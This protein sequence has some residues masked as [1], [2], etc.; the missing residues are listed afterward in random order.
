M[1]LFTYF[2]G[3]SLVFAACGNDKMSRTEADQA[4]NPFSTAQSHS[5]SLSE[6]DKAK[7][8][9]AIGKTSI[10]VSENELLQKINTA[11]DRLH[12]FCF[13]SLKNRQNAESLAAVAQ[14]W[15]STQI[16]ICYINIGDA[17]LNEVHLAIREASLADDNYRLESADLHFLTRVKK[18]IA[19]NLPLI[20]L[21]NKSESL[22]TYYQQSFDAKEM[23]TVIAPLI[24]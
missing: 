7:L 3:L 6:L 17:N 1:K 10:L 12:I 20:L 24:D 16:K 8:A 2:L 22:L 14:N 9:A 15:D 21:V 5:E 18:E 19:P 23:N 13:W 11:A 4:A